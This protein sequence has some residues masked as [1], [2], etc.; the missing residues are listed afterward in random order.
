MGMPRRALATKNPLL[1]AAIIAAAAY[2]VLDGGEMG[3]LYLML[4]KGAGVA[5]LALYAFMQGEGVEARLLALSLALAALGD[6]VIEISLEA[7]GA[8]FLF[9]HLVSIILYWRCKKSAHISSDW[10]LAALIFFITPFGVWVLVQ[11]A[12]ACIYGVTLGAM[13]ASAWLSR[14]KRMRVGLGALMFVFSDW[15]IFALEGGFSSYNGVKIAIWPLYF[16]GQFLIVT[17]VVQA[18]RHEL[19]VQP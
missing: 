13:A 9:S 17:G 4:I 2:Y 1:L 8:A 10:I 12:M 3:G 5:F 18:L 14:F 6:V 16:I 11:D 15:C 7:G 19:S